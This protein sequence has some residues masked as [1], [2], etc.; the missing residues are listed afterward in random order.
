MTTPAHEH[1]QTAQP[2][3]PR[4]AWQQVTIEAPATLQLFGRQRRGLLDVTLIN[5]AELTLDPGDDA[6][7]AFSY[8]L[9][10]ESGT[11]LGF[12]GVRTALCAAVL[13]G[14]SHHQKV[15]VIVPDEYLPQCVAV[16]LGLL[17]EGEYWVESLNPAHPKTVDIHVPTGLTPAEYRMAA[18]GQIWPRGLGNGLRWPYGTMMVAERYKLFYIPVAKCACT[19]L[20]SL[21]VSLAGVYQPKMAQE[22]GIHFVTDQF[23]TGALLK[24]MPLDLARE[25]LAS[26]RHFKFSVIRDPLERLVSAFLEK[27][28]YNRHNP[29]NLWHT[30]P[31]LRAVQG[32]QAIDLD[33]G[34][35]FNQFLEYIVAQ[36]PFDLDNH[37]RP[38]CHYFLGVRHMSRIFRL[39]NIAAL[40]QHLLQQHG[41]EVQ[42]GHKNRTRKS[43]QLL[44]DAA[45]MTA[46][47]LDS[48][49]AVS[50]ASFLSG[51]NSATI[52]QYYREDLDLY[53]SAH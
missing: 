42:L 45:S 18:A 22:L 53:R 46:A 38:Q 13:G 40:E 47:E 21:M 9:L 16:R 3:F 34:I 35:S 43:D 36:D 52:Q 30:G 32:T 37:W 1:P 8:R 24:D 11:D 51:E 48:R 28:V 49:G 10:D 15:T 29:A 39:D 50:P 17:R 14:A 26:D 5:S 31:V 4:D 23:R 20:K 41:I 33:E 2:D 19:S 27:F 44:E 6:T 12:E 7:L 25:L